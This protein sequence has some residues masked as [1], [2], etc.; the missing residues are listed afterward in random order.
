MRDSEGISF[1]HFE[2]SLS[3]AYIWVP[4]PTQRTLCSCDQLGAARTALTTILARTKQLSR[5]LRHEDSVVGRGGV[6]LHR[7]ETSC[8]NGYS[9]NRVCRHKEVSARL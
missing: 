4:A 2:W 6:V 9:F 3:N 8:P 5:V 7:S 1:G